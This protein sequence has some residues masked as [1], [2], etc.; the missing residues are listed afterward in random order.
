M[1][2]IDKRI[3]VILTRI[4]IAIQFLTIIIPIKIKKSYDF[5]DIAHSVIYFPFVG[6]LLGT[7]CVIINIFLRNKLNFFIKDMIILSIMITLTGGIHLSGFVDITEDMIDSK[8]EHDVARTLRGHHIT[9]FG[10][11]ILS[12]L[13]MLKFIIFSN[14]NENFKNSALI[15]FPM[16]SRWAMVFGILISENHNNTSGTKIKFV[17]LV[18]KKEAF[19][20][21]IIPVIITIFVAGLK[22]F[23]LISIMLV[24]TYTFI[25][26]TIKKKY[27]RG[28]DIFGAINETVE[29]IVL[30][31]FAIVY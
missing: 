23:V 4:I 15:I 13:I 28:R 11:I 22:G 16:L 21:G 5:K 2:R 6:Y 9:A 1:E 12:S 10:V 30:L 24:F 17:D 3:G 26:Y 25:F 31:F 20:A 29:L 19:I 7:I 27:S 8:K 18:E 14:I